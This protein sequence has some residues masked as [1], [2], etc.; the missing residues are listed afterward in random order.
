MTGMVAGYHKTTTTTQQQQ[1]ESTSGYLKNNPIFD[2]QPVK[3]LEQWS[4]MLMSALTKTTVKFA[5]WF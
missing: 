1:T 5:A 4:N 2:W 3:C